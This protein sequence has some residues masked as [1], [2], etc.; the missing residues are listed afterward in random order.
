M[1]SKYKL[2]ILGYGT[3]SALSLTTILALAKSRDNINNFTID[4]IHDPLIPTIAVG[5]SLSPMMIKFVNEVIDENIFDLKSEFDGT[6]RYGGVNEWEN[7]LGTPFTVKYIKAGLHVN[8]EK[9]SKFLFNKIRKK[10]IKTF[11]V[12]HGHVTD[13]DNGPTGVTVHTDRGSYNYDYIIDCRGTPT[14]D[15][16]NNG[17]YSFPDFE[18]VNSV[19]IYPDF[20]KYDEIYTQSIF[21]ENGWMFGVPLQHRKAFGYLFNNNITVM[22]DAKIHFKKL[23]P[24]IEVEKLRL[25][26]WRHYYRNKAMDGRIFY[27]GNMLYFFEPAQGLPLHYY[28][29]ISTVFLKL[30]LEYQDDYSSICD[31]IN[32]VH[33]KSVKYDIQDLISINYA[34]ENR[35]SSPFWD[36]MS[37]QATNRLKNSDNFKKFAREKIYNDVYTQFWCHDGKLMKQYIE[38]YN[39]DLNKFV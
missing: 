39:I 4:C 7:G 32:T 3:S 17:S 38:G 18:T 23:I 27:M 34:G 22:E 1:S 15:I 35:M 10:Y 8:S 29:F 30:L 2:G 14:D 12:Y 24:Q 25:L 31:K 13:V 9:F 33:T 26:K 5:E 36:T 6:Y 28:G 11:K 16:L 21:H 19:L 37:V 20:K